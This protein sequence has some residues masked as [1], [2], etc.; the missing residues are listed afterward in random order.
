MTNQG[1]FKNLSWAALG[2]VLTVIA[3]LGL[4]AFQSHQQQM[5]AELEKKIVLHEKME[6]L[7][8][9]IYALTIKIKELESV[10][11]SL[12]GTDLFRKNIQERNQINTQLNSKK[13]VF[14][15]YESELSKLESRPIRNIDLEF[16]TPSP[17]SVSIKAG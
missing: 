2:S 17:P 12:V 15:F 11:T 1:W 4:T 10:A 13:E 14:N 9:E 6:A 16:K 8:P 3:T 5:N 7:L